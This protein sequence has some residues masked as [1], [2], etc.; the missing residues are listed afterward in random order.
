ME[1]LHP[2]EIELGLARI[3]KVADALGIEKGNAQVVTVAGTNG[4]GSCIAVLEACLLGAGQRVGAYTSPHV[5]RYNER[6]RIDGADVNDQALCHAFDR[7]DRA[8]GE[9]SLTYFEF[10]TLAAMLLFQGADVDVWLLEVGLGGR[11]DAVNIIDPD[12]AV[13]TSID[14]DHQA[15][16]GDTRDQIAYEKVGILRSDITCVCA[17]QRLTGSMTRA[18]EQHNVTLYLMGRDFSLAS[19]AVSDAY[20]IQI[21]CGGE[22]HKA[23]IAPPNLPHP[24]VA[25]A[26]QVMA[27]LTKS[28]FDMQACT[29]YCEQLSLSGRYEQIVHRGQTYVLDV[30]HNPAAT[31]LLVETL[32]RRKHRPRIAVVAMMADKDINDTLQAMLPQVEHWVLARCEGVGRSA[33]TADLAGVLRAQGVA[34][35]HMTLC[36]SVEDALAECAKDIACPT[37]DSCAVTVVFGSFYTVAAAKNYLQPET[38]LSETH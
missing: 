3:E 29:R 13:I 1:T 33:S 20:E 15:W 25:S 14:L 4:K 7:I 5:L 28:H 9:I 35:D 27:L 10:G 11:L 22:R 38:N 16:L 6:I 32:Q 37:T 34:D 36:N 21:T 12:I 17:E 26:F 23:T 8:R 18:F 2:K 24:S 19:D 31:G 30:A